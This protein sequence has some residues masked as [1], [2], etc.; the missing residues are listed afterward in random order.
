MDEWAGTGDSAPGRGQDPGVSGR[1]RF[2][3]AWRLLSFEVSVQGNVAHPYGEHPIGRL[4]YDE[5]GRMS[6]QAMR[7][8][9]ESSVDDPGDVAGASY[10]ELRQIAD[11]YIGYYGSF[12]L[13]E[14]SKTVI[15]H[16]E[17]CT[18]PAWVGTEQRRQYEFT[19]AHLT[20]RA[21]SAKL[22]W[23]RLPD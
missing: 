19:G 10:E 16:V 3:G 13:D 5:A 11:G 6:A 22:V 23:E 18:L 20:L 17:C 7:I 9:R 4:T 2:V 12:T 14:E 1:K 8:G 15:H 21:D